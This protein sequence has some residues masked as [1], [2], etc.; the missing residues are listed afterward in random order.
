MLLL[1]LFVVFAF[2]F[3]KAG[4]YGCEGYKHFVEYEAANLYNVS[5][6]RTTNL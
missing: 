6:S 3:S 1:C 5:V 4:A 2:S